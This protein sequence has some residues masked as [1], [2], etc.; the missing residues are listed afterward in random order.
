[1][2]GHMNVKFKLYKDCFSEWLLYYAVQFTLIAYYSDDCTRCLAT[3]NMTVT[4]QFY[5]KTNL[6][7][8]VSKILTYVSGHAAPQYWASQ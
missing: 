4:C 5:A 1:M 6:V 2:Q 7:Q 3:Q 8:Q